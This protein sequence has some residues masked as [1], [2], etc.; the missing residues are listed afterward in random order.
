V[1]TVSAPART[2]RQSSRRT[3]DDTNSRKA[4]KKMSKVNAVT[5]GLLERHTCGTVDDCYAEVCG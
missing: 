5:D 4:S 2:R 1:T 3:V